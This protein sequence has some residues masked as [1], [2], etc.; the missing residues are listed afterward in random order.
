MSLPLKMKPKVLIIIATDIIGGPGKG[1]FQFLKFSKELDFSY[2]LCN[3]LPTHVNITNY[4]FY[5]KAKEEGIN[6]QLL[7]Q[8]M[9][10]DPLLILRAYR[11]SKKHKINIIQT[12]GSKANVI[13]FFLNKMFNIPWI[14]FA[15]GYLETN[16]KIR[17]YE[18]IDRTVLK[19]ADVVI[20]VSNSMKELLR[21]A[22][23]KEIKIK[24]IYNAVDL[25]DNKPTLRNNTI[26]DSYGIKND[27]KVIGV[28]GRL[29]PEKGQII[30]LKAFRKVI[31]IFPD[32]SALI[33][34]DGQD[35][36][37]LKDFCKTHGIDKKV[38]FTGYQETVA[39]FYQIL[40]VLVLPSL[41][42]GLPNTVLEAMSFGIPV[43][44]TSVGGVPEII[45]NENGI[46][47]L[48]GDQESLA[49]KMIELLK[50]DHLRKS[51]GLSGKNSLYPRFSPLYRSQQI[52]DLYKYLLASRF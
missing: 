50:D 8:N 48:P 15:H 41:S 33:I 25:S 38:I 42:E 43:L 23:V 24:V 29:S 49:D 1:L 46:L 47:V 31:E 21:R 12:H 18:K 39:N 28:I 34:G 52:V 32:V 27:H 45:N 20:T 9:A 14:G 37:K 26:K 6:L 2:I 16:K 22:G 11:I 51:L 17:F 5:K 13:G 10:I 19:Y 44:A 35:K 30:F 7:K 40:D 4:E 36:E 3:F